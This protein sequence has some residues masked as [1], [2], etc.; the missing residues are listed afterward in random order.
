QLD[1]DQRHAHEGVDHQ[2]LVEDQVQDVVEAARRRRAAHD[3]GGAGHGDR[4]PSE[5]RLPRQS[6]L[7]LGVLGLGLVL[8]DADLLAV[9][10]GL[11]GL[12]LPVGALLRLGGVLVVGLLGVLRL[13]LIASL[14]VDVLVAGL[15]VVAVLGLLVLGDLAAP[16]AGLL[17][18][19]LHVVL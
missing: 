14:L 16:G 10:G 3:R 13:G 19:Q 1:A 15:L 8:V 5:A 18:G 2:T 12:G 4:L 7:A 11:G 17:T 9:L 6:G